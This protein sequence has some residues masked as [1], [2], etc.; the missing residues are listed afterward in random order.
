MSTLTLRSLLFQIS[1]LKLPKDLNFNK[2]YEYGLQKVMILLMTK[3]LLTHGL[4]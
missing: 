3:Y 4:I 2:I 1:D